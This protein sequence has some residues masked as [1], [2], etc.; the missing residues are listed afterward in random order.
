MALTLAER[1]ARYRKNR[2]TAGENGERQLNTFLPSAAV[3][4]LRRLAKRNGVSQRKM[5]ELLII[6]ADEQVERTLEIDSP[7]WDEYFGVTK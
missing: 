3:Y 6:Q 5:L 2:C 7:E 1:Q 4:A